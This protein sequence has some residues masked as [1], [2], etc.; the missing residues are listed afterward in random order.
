LAIS[1]APAAIP[2]NPNS[3]AMIATT[4][5]M[6]AHFNIAVSPHNHAIV[7]NRGNRTASHA[8]VETRHKRT[9]RD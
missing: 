5:K 1:A 7:I 2:V 9:L 3:A 6:S 4:K 8:P